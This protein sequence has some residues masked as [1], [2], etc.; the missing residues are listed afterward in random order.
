MVCEYN[1]TGKSFVN[2]DSKYEKYSGLAIC[3]MHADK[4]A[5]QNPQGSVAGQYGDIYYQ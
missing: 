5:R 3:T 2:G 4:N 1:I